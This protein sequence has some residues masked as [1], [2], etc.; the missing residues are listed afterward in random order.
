MYPIRI[1]LSLALL[2]A[3]PALQAG[4]LRDAIKARLAERQAARSAD[5]AD[6]GNR[7]D[8]IG[9]VQRNQSY[10]ANPKETLDVYLPPS[11]HGGAPVIFMVHGGAWKI[12][13]KSHGKVVENKLARW[14]PKGFVFISVNYPMLPQADP[15]KQAD[16]VAQG[17]SYAQAH[18]GQWGGDPNKFIL[19]G[20]SAGA[21]LVSLLSADP[22]RAFAQG[23]RP[24]LGTVSLDSAAMDVAQ[25]ME[26]RHFGFYDE[27]FGKDP[28]YWRQASP[29]QQ[30]TSKAPPMLMVCSSRRADS[31]LQAEGFAHKAHS[32]GLQARVLPEDL[33]HGEINDKLGLA[34][35]YTDQVEAFL[36][37]LDDTVAAQLN[38]QA[39]GHPGSQLGSH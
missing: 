6:N 12:G 37:S 14:Q 39:G 28:A 35:A 9:T 8:G 3:A 5:T 19:M 10:G 15:L 20:H 7:S 34:G 27:A 1:I 24:W 30:L 21:H 17:L 2:A 22:G 13:D 18:A 36:A 16:A 33:S 26:A 4:P 23:A 29:L 31:C 38:N 11:N 32:L 25:I